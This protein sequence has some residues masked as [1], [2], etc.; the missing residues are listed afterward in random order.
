MCKRLQ[1]R[2]IGHDGDLRS[3]PINQQFSNIA[4]GTVFALL[5]AEFEV[6]TA[7]RR[8]GELTPRLEAGLASIFVWCIEGAHATSHGHSGRAKMSNLQ[9]KPNIFDRK[10]ML[11]PIR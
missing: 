11:Q 10:L 1:I 2:R 8:G 9:V 7:T 4:F 3:E 5:I 6:T